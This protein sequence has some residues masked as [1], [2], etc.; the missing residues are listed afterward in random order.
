M[1]I[2]WIL[3]EA[4]RFDDGARKTHSPV[5][6]RWQNRLG[7][8]MELTVGDDHEIAGTFRLGAGGADT[9][10]SFHLTGFVEGDALAFCVDF[11]RLGSVASWS[12]HH[13]ADGERLLTLWH[14]AQ[15]V[16]DPSDE[17]DTWR[18]LVAG[19]DEFTRLDD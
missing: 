5:A 7:S 2:E 9:A 11:G 3:G 15:P 12:G 19:A 4:T 13:V 17:S 6:G 16:R 1:F 18:A 14:L 8:T 10:S